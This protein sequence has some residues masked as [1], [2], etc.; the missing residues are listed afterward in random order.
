MQTWIS[1]SEIPTEKDELSTKWQKAAETIGDKCEARVTD[2]IEGM[3]YTFRV[4]AVNAA[5]PGKPSDPSDSV[6]AKSRRQAPHIDRT[7]IKDLTIKAG[8]TIRFDCKCNGER[9]L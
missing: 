2:L 5:G 1:F 9:K 3:S 4:R 7:N 8:Q 6:T